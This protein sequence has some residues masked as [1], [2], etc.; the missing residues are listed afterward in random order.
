MQ[1]LKKIED[2]SQLREHILSKIDEQEDEN[3]WS[4]EGLEFRDFYTSSYLG[5]M[6][7]EQG[8]LY[9]VKS[10]IEGLFN[11]TE[12]RKLRFIN[13][14]FGE[15]HLKLHPELKAEFKACRVGR[16]L[17]GGESRGEL[18]V[19]DRSYVD[20]I[21]ISTTARVDLRI[22]DSR[23]KKISAE[24]DVKFTKSL[25]LEKCE[26]GVIGDD[27]NGVNFND[28]KFLR[29]ASFSGCRF[30]QAPS[31]FKS[32]LHEDTSFRGVEFLDVS[33]DYAWRAYRTL[34][35]HMMGFESDHEAQMFH[36]L[37]LEARYN[38]ELPKGIKIFSDPKGME[39]IAS[40]ILAQLNQYGRNLWMPFLWLVIFTDIF[41]ILYV[42]AGGIGCVNKQTAA[43]WIQG[44]CESA[45]NLI[46]SIR[47][48]FGPFGLILSAYEIQ[49]NT[50]TVKILG[51]IHLL[52]SSVIWFIWILQIRSRFKL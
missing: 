47:N 17:Y 45:P 48:S 3:L 50:L 19:S 10:I 26:I 46:H 21:A 8:S 20:E 27:N 22:Y 4:L 40:C 44:V 41:L 37:E 23:V 52:I 18:L 15:V 24:N 13:C 49:P 16:L 29:A 11:P 34:K 35:H 43:G 36:A 32:N 12:P 30:Y 2:A 5:H 14:R 9:L 6:E 31:F 7:Q 42:G 33:S 38:T 51:F 39:T 25:I 28:A 1:E